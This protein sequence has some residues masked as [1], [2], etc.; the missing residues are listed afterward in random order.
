MHHMLTHVL[1]LFSCPFVLVLGLFLVVL[2]FVS[3]FPRHL[4]RKMDLAHQTQ[5]HVERA[6]CELSPSLSP[7]RTL[8]PPHP[9]TPFPPTPSLLICLLISRSLSLVRALSRLPSRP[10]ALSLSRALAPH[11]MPHCRQVR[12]KHAINVNVPQVR[13]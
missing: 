1:T 11:L 7:S 5:G 8:S 6:R 9:P 13:P 12:L 3:L 2:F 10:L 4:E